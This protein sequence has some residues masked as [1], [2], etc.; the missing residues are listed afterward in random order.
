MHYKH[1]NE[2]FI[3]VA[4]TIIDDLNKDNKKIGTHINPLH[5]L[6]NKYGLLFEPMKWLYISIA[7]MK[8]IIK[9]LKTKSSYGYDEISTNILIISI[10]YII[11]P[12]TYICNQPLAQ[13][14]FPD[15]LKFALVKPIFKNGSKYEPSNYRPISLL[16]TFSKVQN[17]VFWDVTPCGSCKD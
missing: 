3:S 13:G 5:Y 1:S 8:K 17:G 2:P 9:S 14:I 16:S 7:Y 12:L 10:P 15:R 11:S 6:G 4:Q